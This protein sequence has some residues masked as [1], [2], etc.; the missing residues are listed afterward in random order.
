MPSRPACPAFVFARVFAATSLTWLLVSEVSSPGGAAEAAGLVLATQEFV[1]NGGGR[2]S[3]RRW[4]GASPGRTSSL[5]RVGQR[6]VA[7]QLALSPP[8]RQTSEFLG[9]MRWSRAAGE[10][11]RPRPFAAARVSWIRASAAR[12]GLLL[13]RRS[14]RV[15]AP[16][17]VGVA[18][19]PER[20]RR[21]RRPLRD[22]EAEVV[23]PRVAPADWSPGE[24]L[25]PTE[26]RLPASCLLVVRLQQRRREWCESINVRTR[27]HGRLGGRR[28]LALVTVLSPPTQEPCGCQAGEVRPAMARI[29]GRSESARR[30]APRPRGQL[31]PSNRTAETDG[32]SCA[33]GQRL[34][35]ALLRKVSARVVYACGCSPNAFVWLA[36]GTY[37]S[38]ARG[39]ISAR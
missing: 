32:V 26:V 20:D 3:R 14:E 28:V 37:Q 23:S 10:T 25:R 38:V 30:A 7:F 1:A 17:E 35:I 31:G 29:A 9:W 16:L 5:G 22:A 15:A 39:P 8:R 11:A 21:A 13:A 6:G 27:T 2:P 19:R 18:G 24:R 34:G 4:S 36:S 33:S 12:A